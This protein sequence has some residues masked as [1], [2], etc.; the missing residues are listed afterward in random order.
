LAGKPALDEEFPEPPRLRRLRR[1]VTALTVTLIA[2]VIAIVALLVIRLGMIA[3]ASPEL[4]AAVRLPDGE[5][6]RAVTFGDGWV[7]VVT[8]DAEG[9]ERIR[10]LDARTGSERATAE[11]AH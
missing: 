7:A 8:A 4:P 3:P 9:R 1:L 2:G 11:I 6:A 5:T 10:V